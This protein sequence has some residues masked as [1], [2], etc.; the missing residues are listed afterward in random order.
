[1][2]HDGTKHTKTHEIVIHGRWTKGGRS[3]P[4]VADLMHRYEELTK[5]ATD[6]RSYL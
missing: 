3:M 2:N 1:M 5:R 6:L 4:T